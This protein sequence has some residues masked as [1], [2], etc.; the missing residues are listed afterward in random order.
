MAPTRER[1]AVSSMLRAHADGR[2]W[3]A[4]FVAVAAALARPADAAEAVDIA[5]V[6]GGSPELSR[7]LRAEV[8]YAG[9]VAVDG[10]H[11]ADGAPAS[12]RVLSADRVQLSVQRPSDAVRFEQTLERRP[13]EGESFALRVV[14]ALR[15][16]LVDVGW[17][18]PTPSSAEAD[19]APS[20]PQPAETAE[21]SLDPAVES[22]T[23]PAPVG[24]EPSGAEAPSPRHGSSGLRLWLGAGATGA[25]S[26][27]GLRV[28]PHGALSLRADLGSEWGVALTANLPLASTALRGAEGE[29]D[30]AW[31][32]FTAAV[33]HTFP[34]PAAWF[35]GVGLGAGLFGLDA[36]GQARADFSGQS[37]RL[38]CGAAF[39]QL[40]LG[41]ALNGWLRLRATAT[42]GTTAPRPVLRFDGREVASLGRGYASLGLALE[43]SWPEPELDAGSP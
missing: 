1:R 29:A 27:G 24:D 4:W 20:E 41:H 39:A 21:P 10:A 5:I 16:R 30:V 6:E 15:A 3:T 12:L 42:G 38:W 7:K 40:S 32:A 37:E 26:F 13:T 36:R 33:E 14:E 17:T 8:R 35:G 25:W 34:L 18:L 19:V 31:S 22:R 9:F 11:L 23:A 2:R 28:T 43:L